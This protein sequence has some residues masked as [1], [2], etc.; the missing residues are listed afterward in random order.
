MRTNV[1]FK[2]L[3]CKYFNSSSGVS[4]YLNSIRKYEKLSPEEEEET[5]RKVNEGDR[6]ARWKLIMHNQRFIY[7]M[8]KR[9]ARNEDEIMDY[10]NEGN[11]GLENAIDRYELDKGFKF[12]TYAVWYVRREMSLYLGD[13]RNMVR[14][15]NASRILNKANQF[16]EKIYATEGRV[17]AEDEVLEYLKTEHGVE[18]KHSSDLYALTTSSINESVDDDD[19][20]AEECG[21]YVERTASD[22]GY[23]RE[24]NN[25]YNREAVERLTKC[26]SVPECRIIEQRYGLKGRREM[27][28]PDIAEDLGVSETYVSG[29]ID[30][31]LKKMRVHA[32]KCLVNV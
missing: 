9:Y 4:A 7:S 14:K 12:M 10:V 30:G 17:A 20:T 1:D 23:N 16:R 13:M 21:E 22:N 8:A 27:T 11:K 32:K 29:M 18:V 5:I 19:T 6:D 25:D 24:S 15:P 2:A 3:S 26:L 28:V 31:A